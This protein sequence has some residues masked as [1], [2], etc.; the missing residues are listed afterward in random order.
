VQNTAPS[1]A[2][3]ITQPLCRYLCTVIPRC[4]HR[5]RGI[6]RS[7]RRWWRL[8]GA[9]AGSGGRGSGGGDNRVLCCVV[10]C[11]AGENSVCLL[12][13][14]VN[15]SFY[16]NTKKISVCRLVQNFTSLPASSV[17]VPCKFRASR[18]RATQKR[19]MKTCNAF[20]LHV[21]MEEF[22]NFILSASELHEHVA[23][24]CRRA[25][26]HKESLT[27]N[28][29]KTTTTHNQYSAPDHGRR[30]PRQALRTKR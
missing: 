26:P 6:G 17:Q 2:S 7:K 15:G 14:G 19:C 13:F 3:G 16:L 27:H 4:R 8:P 22:V 20:A 11:R 25:P 1:V 9:E 10:C 5:Q 12:R 21:P 30:P 28:Q 24:D 29:Q 23:R 18:A